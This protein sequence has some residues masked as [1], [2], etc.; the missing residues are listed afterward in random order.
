M[1]G[2]NNPSGHAGQ[3]DNTTSTHSGNPLTGNTHGGAHHD[4]SAFG[5]SN[6]GLGGAGHHGATTT[7]AGYGS[8]NTGAGYGSSNTNSGLASAT[9]GTHEHG[10]NQGPADKLANMIPGTSTV[11]DELGSG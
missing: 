1:P 5:S 8:S 6:T 11:M 3:Y 4:P 10:L 9:H 7:G 2:S